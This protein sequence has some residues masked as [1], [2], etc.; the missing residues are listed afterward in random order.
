MRVLVTGLHRSGTSAVA[1][2]LCVAT[3]TTILDDPDEV[4]DRSLFRKN[5]AELGQIVARWE[6]FHIVKA[7]RA[8]EVLDALSH[9][10]P[11]FY[12]VHVVRDPRDVYTSIMEKV[13]LGRPTRMLDNS[14]FQPVAR[15]HPAGVA[16]AAEFY[17]E[18]Q[19]VSVHKRMAQDIVIR[20][21]HFF[22]DRVA[23]ILK[24][25]VLIGM[26]GRKPT[27]KECETQWGPLVNKSTPDIRG[28]GR[29]RGELRNREQND[30]NRALVRYFEIS[31]FCCC[32]GCSP[33]AGKDSLS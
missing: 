5:R 8:T 12:T 14:R 19:L 11:A 27:P 20:Y 21:D 26:T 2:L 25:C 3:D 31:R 22:Y 17:H 15:R 16:A 7:P 4:I 23:F 18:A 1:H 30:F 32:N 9:I 29:W 24:L 10:L 13:R 33:N 6:E 28:P